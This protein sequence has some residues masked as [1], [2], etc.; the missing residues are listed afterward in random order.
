MEF[1]DRAYRLGDAI[2]L[3]VVLEPKRDVD[4]RE[5]RVDLVCE[6]RYTETFT[7]M[8]PVRGSSGGFAS[9]V[10]VPRQQSKSHKETY[11]HSSVVFFNDTSLAASAS[12]HDVRLDIQPEPPPHAE[13]AKIKWT[14]ETVVDV[15]GARDV[16]SREAITIRL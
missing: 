2:R 16:R 15:A 14:L 5:A 13:T 6:E 7:M 1:E 3:R 10:S 12:S 4:L 11:V 8:T 9:Q